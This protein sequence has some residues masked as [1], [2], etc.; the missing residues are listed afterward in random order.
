MSTFVSSE[1]FVNLG[2]CVALNTVTCTP[3]ANHISADK[4]MSTFQVGEDLAPFSAVER[5]QSLEA[6]KADVVA[7]GIDDGPLPGLQLRVRVDLRCL[8]VLRED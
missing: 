4:I 7:A 6:H 2:Y 3:H 8:S 5:V 1:A